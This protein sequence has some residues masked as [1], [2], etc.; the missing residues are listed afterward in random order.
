MHDAKIVAIM[1]LLVII[2]NI[3]IEQIV[4]VYYW[5][6]HNYVDGEKNDEFEMSAI[7]AI[8]LVKLPE[9]YNYC[10]TA[11]A[12]ILKQII[13]ILVLIIAETIVVV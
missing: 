12:L 13:M 8:I 9:F 7:V 5:I 4:Q 3:G 11:C 6:F 2:S 10:H 1:S